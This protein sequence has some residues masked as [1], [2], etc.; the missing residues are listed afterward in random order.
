MDKYLVLLSGCPRGGERTWASMYKYVLE[1]LNADLALLCSDKW[2]LN[3]SLYEKAKY[4]WVYPEYNNYQ[5]YYQI[6]FDHRWKEYFYLGE[7]TGLLTSGLIHFA[8]KDIAL[9]RHIGEI[10]KYDFLIYTRFDQFYTDYTP[11][12]VMDQI[13]I[14]EGED[15]GGVCD[16]HAIIPRQYCRKY[17][18]LCEFVDSDEAFNYDSYKINS[19]QAFKNH[20][21]SEGLLE[22]IVRYKRNQFIANLK[23]EPTNWRAA[24]LRL[25]G[26]QNLM[27]KYPREF[28]GA[29]NNLLRNRGVI[30]ALLKEPIV[31]A[32][33][34]YYVW[35]KKIGSIRDQRSVLSENVDVAVVSHSGIDTSFLIEYL[36]RYLTVNSHEDKDM[37]KHTPIPPASLN[38]KVK[39]IY[40]YGNPQFAAISLF[41]KRRCYIQSAKPHG[42]NSE[43]SLIQ[44]EMTLLEYEKYKEDLLGFQD[45]FRNWYYDHLPACPTLF[46]KYESL[47][48]NINHLKEFLELPDDFSRNFPIHRL[49]KSSPAN[50]PEGI[51]DGL[52]YIFGPFSKELDKHR[53]F[54]VRQKKPPKYFG[55]LVLARSQFSNVYTGK[56]YLSPKGVLRESFPQIFKAIKTFR[57]KYIPF[58]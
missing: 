15:Y 30:G 46:I 42:Y 4:R 50:L 20:L 6:N 10:E 31:I 51:L 28:F 25:H 16:R 21:S 33:Y 55:G 35:C 7:K 34:F 32:N 47:H 23:G 22:K 9:K 58:T 8:I 3:I 44:K 14:P 18:S 45:H 1:P 48:N 17:L 43:K 26:I 40:I 19:E 54:E 37:V 39:F 27:V 36:S 13:L 41:K 38:R 29:T 57:K 52:N 2:N 5:E 53:Q 12:G 24:K 56:T 49:D 11:S